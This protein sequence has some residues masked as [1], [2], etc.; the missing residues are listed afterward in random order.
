V[1]AAGERLLLVRNRAA[2]E[3]RYG[4]A[5]VQCY[6]YTGRLS[7]DGELVT[8]VNEGTIQ[9]ALEG[10]SFIPIPTPTPIQSF[11][12][13]DQ[14][15]WPTDADGLGPSLTLLDPD[16]APDHD[17]AASWAASVPTP[18]SGGIDYASWQIANFGAGSPPG[19]GPTEDFNGDGIP[20]LIAFALSIS[21]LVYEP[22]GLPV[23][24]VQGGVATF[25]FV[26][27]TTLTGIS[28]EVQVSSDLDEWDPLADVVIDSSGSLDTRQAST[29]NL[30]LF[31]R[32]TV[33][34]L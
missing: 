16:S 23:L 31:F 22:A 11:T 25:T 4:V 1:L 21:P 27:D 33:T 5:P 2:F 19:S 18:G 30:R 12:Y 7:N 9:F 15:P 3:A 6:E 17:D 14:V 20:N 13:N 28:C 32:L 24:D 10:G 8:L 26:Q 29:T 34:Q